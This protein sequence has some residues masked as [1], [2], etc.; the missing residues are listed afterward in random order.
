M[1]NMLMPTKHQHVYSIIL[2]VW[3]VYQQIFL[4]FMVYFVTSLCIPVHFPN[5]RFVCQLCVTGEDTLVRITHC[6]C[7]ITY[8]PNVT[9]KSGSIGRFNYFLNKTMSFVMNQLCQITTV[10][11][12]AIDLKA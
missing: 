12:E 8:T 11:P 1:V 7:N 10:K 3:F 2:T 9:A 6:P 4:A 5:N